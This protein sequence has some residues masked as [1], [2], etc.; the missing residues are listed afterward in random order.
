MQNDERRSKIDE[1]AS[2][3]LLNLDASFPVF[4]IYSEW[5]LKWVYIH[6]DAH[7]TACV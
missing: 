7:L 6:V 4:T 5:L 3:V 1:A 2:S